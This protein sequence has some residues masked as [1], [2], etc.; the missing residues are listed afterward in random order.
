MRLGQ[1]SVNAHV[2]ED[3]LRVEDN[4]PIPKVLGM[5]HKLYLACST[6]NHSVAC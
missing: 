5:G 4:Q 3:V 6:L 2:Y 1:F